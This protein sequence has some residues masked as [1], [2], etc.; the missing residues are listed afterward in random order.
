MNLKVTAILLRNENLA[1]SQEK[2]DE[3]LN[4]IQQQEFVEVDKIYCLILTK[5]PQQNVVMNNIENIF[6]SYYAEGISQILSN[7]SETVLILDISKEP[8]YLKKSASY[9]FAMAL[10]RSHNTGLVY[11]DY[12]SIS[13]SGNIEHH[14]L[15]YHSGRVRDSQDLG[16]V[17]ACS[18]ES[19]QN[20]ELTNWNYGFLYD[21]R[22]KISEKYDLRHLCNR[23]AGEL[24]FVENIIESYNVFAYLQDDQA[25]QKEME[26]IFTEHL[27][28]I[29][30]YLEP[31]TF[32][33]DEMPQYKENSM[34]SIIIPVYRRPEFIGLALESAREQNCTTPLEIIVVVNGGQEDPTISEV[35]RYQQ[36]GDRY[37]PNKPEIHLIVTDINNIGLCLNLGIEHAKGDYYLQL[38]SDDRLKPF[39]VERVLQAFKENPTAAMVI[40]SY[41]VWEKTTQGKIIRRED[42]PVVKHEEWTAE[43]GRNNLLRIN[44][45]GAPRAY[46]IATVKKEGYFSLNDEPYSANYGEDYEMVLKLS[47]RYPIARIF[48]PIYDVVRHQGST[49]HSIDQAT[50]DRNNNAKDEMRHRTIQARI[51]HNKKK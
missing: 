29:G 51:E 28:R 24:Y 49:D 12:T 23:F 20:I 38:D 17:F 41:E 31:H 43:N 8:I 34:V 19:L 25:V 47:E 6:V 11:A 3:V 45:A 33:A 1:F 15:E 46:H 32:S 42:I 2:F 27:K 35:K 36:G 48:E 7:L 10:Q 13:S 50:I 44:G 30:A 37:I 22:L 5:T 40:G 9:A 14:L 4:L 39:A 18:K 21:L 26:A 16:K